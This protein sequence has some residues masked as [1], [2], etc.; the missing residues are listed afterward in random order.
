VSGYLS[1]DSTMVF[2][3]N[4]DKKGASLMSYTWAFGKDP[5]R[6]PEK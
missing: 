4:P 5:E 2:H 3:I 6:S 1:S